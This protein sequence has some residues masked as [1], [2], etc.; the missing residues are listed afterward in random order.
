MSIQ[1]G[2]DVT[3]CLHI[4]LLHSRM[5]YQTLLP[6]FQQQEALFKDVPKECTF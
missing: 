3:K 5:E 2:F 1:Q 4:E 6:I